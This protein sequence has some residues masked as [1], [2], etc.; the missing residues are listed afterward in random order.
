[1]NKTIQVYEPKK[2][3]IIDTPIQAP[4]DDEV[5]IKT[6]YLG[7]CGSDQH[8]YHGSYTGPHT[9][10]I[11]MG[12][13]VSGVVTAVGKDVTT[14]KVG[15]CVVTEANLWC[16]EC[17]NCKLDKNLCTTMEKRSL[18]IDGA[19]R[20]Y[21]NIKG[22]YAYTVPAN[23][24]PKIA[25]LAEPMAVAYNGILTAMGPDPSIH[26]NEFVVVF[27]AGPIGM[28][29][30]MLLKEHFGFARVEISDLVEERLAFANAHGI[31]TYKAPAKVDPNFKKYGE[32]YTGEVAPKFMFE[33]TGVGPV[34]D[35]MFHCVAPRGTIACFAPIKDCHLIGGFL[36]LKAVTLVGSIGGAGAIPLTVQALAGN[37]AYYGD[38]ITD[39]FD[40]TE[41]EEAFEVQ[42]NSTTRMKVV[43]SF[44]DKTV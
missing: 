36:V 29:A 28:A 6:A 7:L 20:Q 34:L 41:F 27:G 33:S 32:I 9:Y 13:E 37:P 19:A 21:F 43:L 42:C 4:K 8:M 3:Q 18:T 16:G 22:K 35:T 30:A 44:D 31:G 1:M 26:K 39:L 14:H 23:V 12:H 11:I 24:S 5:Q 17:D 2:G 40:Y 25:C 15:D 38:L 10:P